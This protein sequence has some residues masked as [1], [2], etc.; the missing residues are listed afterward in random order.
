MLRRLFTSGTRVK[1]LTLFLLDPE[2]ERY[3]RGME[4]DIE[5]NI[6]AI[7]RELRNL[8]ELGLVTSTTRGKQRFYSVNR[9]SPLYPELSGLVLKTQGL[10]PLIRRQLEGL[11][12]IGY[13]F[14]YGPSAR[15]GGVWTGD[16]NLFVM[17]DADQGRFRQVVREM[18]RHLGREI[19]SLLLTPGEFRDRLGNSDPV[20]RS[21]ME[22][23]K[24]VIIPLS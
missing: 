14:L 2:R 6:N 18:E 1:L 16:L 10:V 20:L 22:G 3:P 19:R 21:L 11:E 15:E 24:I 12:G 13:A 17:G 5:E 8:E 7:R 4:R 23:P 9:L